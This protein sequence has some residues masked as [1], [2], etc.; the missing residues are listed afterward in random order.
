MHIMMAFTKDLLMAEALEAARQHAPETEF[1]NVTDEPFAYW[2]AVEERWMSGDDLATI[3]HDNV[4][5]KDTV[6]SFEDCPMPWCAF[7]YPTMPGQEYNLL[8]YGLGCTRFRKELMSKVSPDEIQEVWGS[9][10]NCGPNNLRGCWRH[11]DGKIRVV[12]Q[13]RGFEP[14]AHWP[15][16]KHLNP[17]VANKPNPRGIANEICADGEEFKDC[18]CQFHRY[19]RGEKI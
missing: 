2:K 6:P 18:Q 10:V 3:E 13:R 8:I 4:I 19:H 12:L 7:G 17:F 9:C 14:H 5:T 1:I 16:V 11:I 15:P